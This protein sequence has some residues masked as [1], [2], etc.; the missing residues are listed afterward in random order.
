MVADDKTRKLLERV[1]AERSIPCAFELGSIDDA[2]ERF[3]PDEPADCVVVEIGDPLSEIDEVAIL[4]GQ[5]PAKT[6]FVLIGRF[7]A[8]DQAELHAAGASICIEKADLLDELDCIFGVPLQTVRSASPAVATQAPPAPP[9]PSVI[10]EA[11]IRTEPAI[12]V[13]D[14]ISQPAM[15]SPSAPAARPWVAPTE[16][17]PDRTA[18]IEPPPPPSDP[19][20]PVP[21]EDHNR[22]AGQRVERQAS[23]SHLPSASGLHQAPPSYGM[24]PTAPVRRIGR[25]IVVVGCRGGVG[26]TSIAVSLAWL[27]GEENA[28]STA[29]LDLDPHFGS[30]ALALN[31][32]PGDGL[33][34]ALERPGRI[35]NVFLERAVRK[36]GQNLFVLSS[37]R[38]LDAPLCSDVTA[39][40]SLIKALSQQHERVIV[41]LPR[42]DPETMSRVLVL[43]DEI[44]LVTDLSLAGARDAVR[45]LG[46][47]RKVSNYARVRV[48]GGG[49]RDQGKENALSPSEFRKAAGISFEIA[50]AHD[51]AAASEAAR[52]GRPIAKVSPRGALGKTL[53]GLVNMVEPADQRA[54]KRR[55]LF[56]KQ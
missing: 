24:P 45:L 13:S 56:W 7:S 1:A 43:A 20:A 10:A 11:N 29:L 28:M 42:H 55:L 3:A 9:A 38:A 15:S 19:P 21:A 16:A 39:P 49:A 30:V 48:I 36:V 26:A 12:T 53:R 4:A 8:A 51:A 25:T 31:L 34:Q 52:S 40:A 22:L 5:M 14:S 32:D 18:R 23:G 6:N 54:R 41:D 37:E 17:R 2:L 50:L 33:Q 27:L 47:A 46:L 44:L 35:D